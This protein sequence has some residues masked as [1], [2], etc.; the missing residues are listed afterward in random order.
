LDEHLLLIAEG[1]V[2]DLD[3]GLR[4]IG[5]E[6]VLA[7]RL[8]HRSAPAVEADLGHLGVGGPDPAGQVAADDAGRQAG[9]ADEAEKGAALETAVLV[10]LQEPF[11]ALRIV[12]GPCLLL[13]FLEAEG[14]PGPRGPGRLPPVY[15]RPR[16][17]IRANAPASS[18]RPTVITIIT[19]PSALISGLIE[20]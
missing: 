16:N 9:A 11:I 5:V 3:A 13:S 10:A 12:H 14:W 20:L 6:G 4:G 8:R 1:G 19:V 2:D 7:Q 17:I 18:G 15:T